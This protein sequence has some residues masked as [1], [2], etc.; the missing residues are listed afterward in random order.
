MAKK[1]RKGRV[2]V[3]GVDATTGACSAVAVSAQAGM[4]YIDLHRLIPQDLESW[5]EQ[6]V[7]D[8]AAGSRPRA[9]RRRWERALVLL[10]HHRSRLACELLQELAPRVP[11]KLRELHA[12]A[13]GESHSWFGESY[14]QGAGGEPG[15]LVPGRFVSGAGEQ[16]VGPN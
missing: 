11:R 1:K 5:D 9:S 16:G 6:R 4:R 15:E 2:Y 3:I 13:L 8:L 12:M 14:E 7:R 10:A